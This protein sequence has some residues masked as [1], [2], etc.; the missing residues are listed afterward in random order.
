MRRGRS[1]FGLGLLALFLAAGMLG[2]APKDKKAADR[3]RVVSYKELGEVVKKYRGKNV[4]VVEIW[5][6]D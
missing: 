3:S 6:F 5:N 1:Y 4:L 2:A